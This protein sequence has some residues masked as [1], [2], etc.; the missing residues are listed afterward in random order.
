[1][2]K[3]K[4]MKIQDPMQIFLK[5]THL[6]NYTIISYNIEIISKIVDYLN[7]NIVSI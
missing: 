1:M 7:N 2:T 4:D 6:G 5:F 3:K